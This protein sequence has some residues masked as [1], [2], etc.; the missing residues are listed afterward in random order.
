MMKLQIKIK[1]NELS[2][3]GDVI[4]KVKEFELEK[5]PELNPEVVIE[6]GD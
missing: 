6:L 3:V 1:V 5:S 4:K 2:E